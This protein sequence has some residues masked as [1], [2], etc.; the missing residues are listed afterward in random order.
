MTD[1][2]IKMGVAGFIIGALFGLAAMWAQ[3]S[4][5]IDHNRRTALDCGVRCGLTGVDRA[6]FADGECVCTKTSARAAA[7]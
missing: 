5:D 1:R 7:P 3:A 2:E 6:V 4:D